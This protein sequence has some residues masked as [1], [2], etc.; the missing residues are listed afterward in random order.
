MLFGWY[1]KT[2]QVCY[3]SCTRGGA[4]SASNPYI[5]PSS[6]IIS[7]VIVIPH[8]PAPPIVR[9]HGNQLSLYNVPSHDSA[10]QYF[11]NSPG[12][13]IGLCRSF[14]SSRC[15]YRTHG[16]HELLRQKPSQLTTTSAGLLIRG[17]VLPKLSRCKASTLYIRY[18]SRCAFIL[19]LSRRWS[20][21]PYFFIPPLPVVAMCLVITEGYVP[22]MQALTN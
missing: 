10:Q 5:S 3:E 22:S 7:A 21:P 17:P 16:N 8:R 19:I 12:P 18:T 15:H 6:I 4:L 13:P 11:Y 9:Y 2:T 1:W 20:L 14:L